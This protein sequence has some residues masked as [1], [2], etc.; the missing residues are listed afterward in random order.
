MISLQRIWVLALSIAIWLT[1]VSGCSKPDGGPLSTAETD[2]IKAASNAYGTAWL[3]NDADQ[4]MATLTDDA[5]IVPSG[6]SPIQGQADIRSF[7]W[8]ADS[9][10]TTVTQFVS[11][12]HSAGGHGEVGFVLG[13]FTLS[14]DYDGNSYSSGGTYMSVL[15]RAVDGSWKISH[16]MWSDSP[17]SD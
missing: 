10:P 6:M 12:V 4:V 14:F 7:W 2:A 16:R 8:P 17:R 11:T 13:S 5:V 15:R 9:P 1:G 3:S